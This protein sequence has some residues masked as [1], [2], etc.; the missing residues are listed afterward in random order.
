MH[1]N[2]RSLARLYERRGVQGRQRCLCRKTGFGVCRGGTQDGSGRAQIQSRRAG[3]ND[4]AIRRL[5]QKGGGDRQRRLD[6]RSDVLSHL[7]SRRDEK[8]RLGQA[9]RWAGSAG[10][11]LGDVAGAGAESPLQSKPLGRERDDLPD[12]PLLLGLRRRRNDRLGRAPD[13]SNPPVLWRTDADFHFGDGRQAICGR[14][15][16]DARH[17]DGYVPLS[18]VPADLRKPHRQPDA[19]VRPGRLDFRAI[20][21]NQPAAA[22][23]DHKRGGCWL[24]PN[25]G[26]KV[27]AQ[28]YENNQEMRDLNIPHWKNFIECVKSRAK[29][30]SDI[31][32]CVRSSTACI[33]A[34]LS[35]RHKT[36]LDWDETNWTVKQNHIK[37]FLKAKYRAPWKLE[38]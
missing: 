5:F 17:A 22:A 18:E 31:E 16:G 37:P 33:L 28:T 27:E 23:V 32:T 29:P 34:N 38:V 4:A 2:P 19:D 15:R 10:I 9:C 8:A 24:V 6:R 11:G 12:L 13:R 7:A 1:F 3:G 26:S 30:T 25:N 20:V 14:Q 36:W 35:M 21:G